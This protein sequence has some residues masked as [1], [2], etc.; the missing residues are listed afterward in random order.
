[1][2]IDPDGRD[3]SFADDSQARSDFNSAFNTV[4]SNVGYYQGRV[5]QNNSLSGQKGFGAWT[6]RLFR[7]EKAD[8]RNLA[9]W[10]KLESDFD[11]IV[12]PNTPTVE[13]S[14]ST[15]PLSSNENGLTQPQ[16]N[17]G[18]KV[19][20]RAGHLSAYIHENRHV[21]QWFAGTSG[22]KRNT[23]WFD[24]IQ[25]FQYEAIFDPLGVQGLVSRAAQAEHGQSWQQINP[26]YGITDMV[27]YLYPGIIQSTT[28]IK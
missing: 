17:G 23:D 24:E 28:D 5:D 14:S 10:Q 20:I 26:S 3:T 7:N 2:F 4:K 9:N 6:K 1:M 8:A 18:V 19:N 16:E 27:K 21:N 22:L 15:S 25:A 11:E 13:Y 12:D